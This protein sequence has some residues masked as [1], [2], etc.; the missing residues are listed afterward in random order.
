MRYKELRDELASGGESDE[1][2]SEGESDELTSEGES[3]EVP[4]SEAVAD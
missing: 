4:I 3:D 1:L 2:A